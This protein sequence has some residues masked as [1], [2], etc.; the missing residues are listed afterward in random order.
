LGLS[1]H[2]P[3]PAKLDKPGASQINPNYWN[4]EVITLSFKLKRRRQFGIAKLLD[5]DSAIA[6]SRLVLGKTYIG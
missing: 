6:Y 5:T 3:G 2:P 4:V 1:R